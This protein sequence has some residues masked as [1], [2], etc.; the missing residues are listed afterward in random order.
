MAVI[1]HGWELH[2]FYTCI[3]PFLPPISLVTFHLREL[4]QMTCRSL[5]PKNLLYDSI[6]SCTARTLRVLQGKSTLYR[7]PTKIQFFIS[8]HKINNYGYGHEYLELFVECHEFSKYISTISTY[9][10]PAVPFRAEKDSETQF[11]FI[12][13]NI[14]TVTATTS[15]VLVLTIVT[16]LAGQKGLAQVVG[17]G[18]ISN[19]SR[20]MNL[21]LVKCH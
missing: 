1:W 5:S 20:V 12:C 3:I 21:F 17:T 14:C 8:H 16:R 2:T 6:N 4:D 9:E 7:D 13:I 11:A 18:G 15:P 10:K 19:W